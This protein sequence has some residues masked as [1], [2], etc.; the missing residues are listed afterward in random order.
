LDISN[1]NVQYDL[2]SKSENYKV[3]KE[4]ADKIFTTN[5]IK[6]QDIIRGQKLY[7]KSKK[8]KRSRELIKE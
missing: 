5:E 3:Y 8:L 6:K 4:K 1:L 2:L 7:K